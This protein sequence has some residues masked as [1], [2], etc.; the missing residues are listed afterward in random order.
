[1]FRLSHREQLRIDEAWCII[2]TLRQRQGKEWAV[3][4]FWPDH[5]IGER[6]LE[7]SW[8]ATTTT[9]GCNLSFCEPR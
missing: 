5:L 2:L 6:E 4:A 3:H 7:E 8:D 1:M 9:D